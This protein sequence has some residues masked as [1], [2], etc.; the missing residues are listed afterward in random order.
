MLL[1]FD[2]KIFK[3]SFKWKKSLVKTLKKPWK[4]PCEV[5]E[6]NRGF[7]HFLPGFFHCPGRN[8]IDHGSFPT[9]SFYTD[10]SFSIHNSKWSIFHNSSLNFKKWFP[11]PYLAGIEILTTEL[12]SSV[13]RAG[14]ENQWSL[15]RSPLGFNFFF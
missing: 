13:V 4:K 14:L 3:N 8:P 10:Y 12:Y 6:K 9:L 2:N 15:V 7:F 5:C 1:K 11:N